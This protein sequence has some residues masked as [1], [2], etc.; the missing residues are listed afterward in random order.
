MPRRT[1]GIIF[2]IAYAGRS[3]AEIAKVCCGV[4]VSTV[5]ISLADINAIHE[6]ALEERKQAAAA[7]GA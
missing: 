2:G 3:Y 6:A 7:V 4:R 1:H 5:S